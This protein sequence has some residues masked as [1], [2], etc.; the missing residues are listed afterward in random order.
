MTPAAHPPVR[1]H[2]LYA[3]HHRLGQ[4]LRALPLAL[5]LPTLAAAQTPRDTIDVPGMRAFLGEVGRSAADGVVQ[6]QWLADGRRLWFTSPGEGGIDT[7]WLIELTSTNGAAAGGAARP[8]A[9]ASADSLARAAAL[10]VAGVTARGPATGLA[11]SA[12]GRHVRFAWQGRLLQLD[13]ASGTAQP[14]SAAEAETQRLQG[15]QRPRSMFPINGW[16]RPEMPSPDGTQFASYEGWNLALRTPGQATRRLLTRNGSERQPWL[17][18]AEILV[19]RGSEWSADGR[20]LV[21]RQLDVRHVRGVPMVDAVSGAAEKLSTFRYWVRAGE[22]LPRQTLHVID[23]QRKAASG[24]AAAASVALRSVET[25]DVWTAFLDWRPGTSE[26][27]FF[28]ASRDF[29]RLTLQAADARTGRSRV[30]WRE[31]RDDGYVFFPFT[32]S[33]ILQFTPDGQ[34]FVWHSDRGGRQA[35]WL[36]DS[37]SGQP[38]RAISPP[39]LT[40]SALMRL[41]ASGEHVHAMAY[42]D[43]ARPA[44]SHHVRFRLADGTAQVLSTEPGQRR[45]SFSPDGRWFVETHHD[46]NRAP[47]SELKRA[48]GAL[49]AELARSRGLSPAG[50]ESSSA[51]AFELQLPAG[52]VSGVVLRPPGFDPTRRYPVIERLYAGMQSSAVPRGWL[53]RAP[54][55]NSYVNLLQAYL[56]AGFVVVA[57]DGPG[58]PGRD[59]AHNLAP[60]GIWPRGIAQVHAQA[61]AELARTRPWMDLQRLG[62]DGN[63]WGGFVGLHALVELPELY[64]AAVLTVPQTDPLDHL[65]WIE[66]KLGTPASNPDGYAAA[67]VLHR[68]DRLRAALMLIAGTT[69]GNV[70]Y[71]NTLKA[72]NALADAGQPYELV[73]L[74]NVNHGLQGIADRYPYAVARSVAF[75]QRTLGGP[76]AAPAVSAGELKPGATPP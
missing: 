69:D 45:V 1:P 54:G 33:P 4:L 76:V 70:P 71:S 18:G 58:T 19:G 40:V 41:D 14:L 31:T 57:M 9:L 35:L 38:L 17:L 15:V 44:D 63:S 43:P 23:T 22:P 12:D 62:L 32:G 53:G 36:H 24:A 52:P 39:G 68:M 3:L 20:Y 34:R 72:V 66:F 65:S 6:P 7:L 46:L 27:W 8:Q 5:W 64:R 26:V 10:A 48:D 37:T 42:A 51:E 16:D 28:T 47:R 56:R 21:G 67:R 2:R 13:I 75:F 55:G 30:V 50:L 49:V 74:P 61:L 29:S 11:L 60:F 59:R 73:L 25:D